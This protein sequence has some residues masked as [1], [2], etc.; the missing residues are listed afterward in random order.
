MR[1]NDEGVHD[2]VYYTPGGKMVLGATVLG[3]GG[4]R[5]RVGSD[6]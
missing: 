4:W 3:I 1:E 2:L 6:S 5:E